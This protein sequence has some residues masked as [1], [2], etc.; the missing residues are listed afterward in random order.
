[1]KIIVAIIFLFT[2]LL[3]DEIKELRVGIYN[4]P[5][6]IFLEDEKPSGFFVDIINEIASKE[7]WRL[8]FVEC[9]W[10]ECLNKLKKGELDIMPDVA[11]SVQRAGEFNFNK[12][13][14]LVSHSVVFSNKKSDISSVMD[15]NNKKI[16]L[17]K[18]SIQHTQFIDFISNFGIKVDYVFTNSF[19]EAFMLVNSMEADAV[20]TSKYFGEYSK[21]KFK[22]ITETP[23]V[24]YS[25][26]LKFAFCKDV[27]NS[28]IIN[29]I[30]KHILEFKKSSDSILQRA[31]KRY[32]VQA[33]DKLPSWFY[34]AVL[35][36]ISIII[37]LVTL[38]AFFKYMLN[39]KTKE[40]LE[41]S[42]E[43][44]ELQ[45]AKVNDYKNMLFALIS[46]VEQR[47]NYTAGHSQRVANYSVLIA[48]EMGYSDADCELL[49]EA[50]ILHDIGKIAIPDA[51]LLKPEKLT[52]LEYNI[53]KEHIN[54]G[55]KMLQDLPMYKNILNIM[56]HHHEKYNGSGYPYQISK[57]E[58]PP[59]SR[60][61][62]VADAFD[63][64]TTNR[65]YK[66]KKSVSE[67]LEEI[68]SLNKIHFHPEVVEAALKALA[69][70]DISSDVSQKPTTLLEEQRFVYFYKDALTNLY[71]V[72][73][74]ETTLV[75]NTD[76]AKYKQILIISLHKFDIYNKKY[77]WESGDEV[78]KAFAT[79]LSALFEKHLIFRVRA[80]DFIILLEDNFDSQEQRNKIAHFVEEKEIEFDAYTYDLKSNGI[81][82]YELLKKFL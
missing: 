5:P 81:Y 67:A 7:N 20:A 49:H 72:K 65:I 12:E 29:K 70:V 35:S 30:D 3:A 4:N 52:A 82:S 16:A 60:I 8:T 14:V 51:I 37:F 62:M 39:K 1:M 11:F 18:N 80:N 2:S 71:N 23:I 28:D 9:E 26:P 43:V 24:L 41:K 78:L 17:L 45:K 48:K 64:M 59:L 68:A 27:N 53:I 25:A 21:I 34:K 15:L 22:N 13:V 46:M 77:G 33:N 55:L 74:L 50:S 47:D 57:N 54:V 19:E 66:H 44:I 58:I 56:K 36:V 32:L 73:F 42:N 75:G 40:S 76:A 79:L 31:T 61:M 6:K 10:E 69:T 63:A 38:I